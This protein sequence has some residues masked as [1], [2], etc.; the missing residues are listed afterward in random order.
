M[1]VNLTIDSPFEV[2]IF[3]RAPSENCVYFT[4]NRND[5]TLLDSTIMSNTSLTF[6]E[7][8]HDTPNPHGVFDRR[9]HAFQW[10]HDREGNDENY[11]HVLMK[12]LRF[13][14]G[15]RQSFNTDECPAAL[16]SLLQ[17]RLQ[18]DN[19][20]DVKRRIEEHMTGAA[21]GNVETGAQLLRE[22]TKIYE[23]CHDEELTQI[24]DELARIVLTPENIRDNRDIVVDDCLLNLPPHYLDIAQYG[25]DHTEFRIRSRYCRFKNCSIRSSRAIL[26][27]INRNELDAIE[28]EELEKLTSFWK[29][30][31]KWP[32]IGIVTGVV[33]SVIVSIA[34]ITS[35]LLTSSLQLVEGDGWSL[36]PRARTLTVWKDN[37]M[38]K[39][40]C[41]DRV[42]SPSYYPWYMNKSSIEHV[43]I[44]DSVSFVGKYAFD[45]YE[46][47]KTV[48][49]EEGIKN[50]GDYSFRGCTNL[51]SVNIPSSVTSIGEEAFSSCS[52]TSLEIP[53]NVSSIGKNAFDSCS[54]LSDVKYSGLKDPCGY[55]IFGHSF[56]SSAFGN[57]LVKNVAAPYYYNS[58]EFCGV[59]LMAHPLEI[60]TVILSLLCA[61]PL[62]C[63]QLVLNGLKR[64]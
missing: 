12:W 34:L 58:A 45:G 18:F 5:T 51:K 30:L 19:L 63:F 13:C 42:R 21:R 40:H 8:L 28:I 27:G 54:N 48:V 52:L 62:L 37:A 50:I 31:M 44:K 17:L 64:F 36:N 3:G 38:S 1:A 2:H 4:S 39:K 6:S 53:L 20:D 60:L 56:S 15:E 35:L 57:T 16:G 9:S 32:Q 33:V 22:C 26:A 24:G 47:L 29:K 46:S 11:Q 7:L 10:N 61:I 14:Y 41:W 43:V 25:D 23:E 49:F 55:N 59:S